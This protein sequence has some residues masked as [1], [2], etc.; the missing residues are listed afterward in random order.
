M[1]APKTPARRA[2]TPVAD[3]PNKH[4]RDAL[5]YAE[6]HGWT[7][8]KSGPRAHAWGVIFCSFGHRVCWMAVYSTHGSLIF[9]R[10][11]RIYNALYFLPLRHFQAF[12]WYAKFHIP[13]NDQ[14]V[15]MSEKQSWKFFAFHELNFQFLE[16][17][18]Q[19]LEGNFKMSE[20]YA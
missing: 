18:F 10:V 12:S 3:H 11:L 16:L 1:A 17:N 19:F 20:P 13:L 2:E 6:E 9:I 4:I 5:E 7:M 8:R 15:A 14:L